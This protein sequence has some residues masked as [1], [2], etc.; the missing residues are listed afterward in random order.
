MGMMIGVTNTGR[1]VIQIKKPDG[2]VAG[3]ISFS[4]PGQKK[5]KKLNYNFKA[6]SAQI[7]LSKTSNSARKAVTKARGTVAMLLRNMMIWIWNMRLYMRG[8]WSALP[9][10][11]KSI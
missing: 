11:E 3:S 4:K 10:R 7:L 9:K 1:A 5:T 2:T 8:K 6:V